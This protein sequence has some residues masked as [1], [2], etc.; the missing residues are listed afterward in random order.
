MQRGKHKEA[1]A[2]LDRAL[3]ELGIGAAPK[4]GAQVDPHPHPASK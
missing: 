2:V 4:A 3:S 1:E